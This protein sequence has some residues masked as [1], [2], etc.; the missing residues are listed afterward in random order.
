MSFNDSLAQ[1]LAL[2]S[3]LK[4]NRMRSQLMKA[5]ADAAARQ[6][7]LMEEQ[8]RERMQR[9]EALEQSGNEVLTAPDMIFPEPSD[10]TIGQ[11]TNL[12]LGVSDSATGM[13]LTADAIASQTPQPNPAI[14]S[15]LAQYANDL[16]ALRTFDGSPINSDVLRT[17]GMTPDQ[18]LTGNLIAS[19]QQLSADQLATHNR[20]QFKAVADFQISFRD[21]M[22]DAGINPANF[23]SAA[24]LNPGVA[25][26]ELAQYGANVGTPMSAERYGKHVEAWDKAMQAQL[27]LMEQGTARFTAFAEAY[28]A[29]HDILKGYGDTLATMKREGVKKDQWNAYWEAV[30]SPGLQHAADLSAMMHGV[31]P[32]SADPAAIAAFESGDPT[33]IGKMIA[34]ER[35]FIDIPGRAGVIDQFVQGGGVSGFAPDGSFLPSPAEFGIRSPLAPPPTSSGGGGRRR[36][37]VTAEDA[38]AA[39]ASGLAAGR[40]EQHEVAVL[41][42]ALREGPW[43]PDAI[44]NIANI[45]DPKTRAMIIEDMQKNIDARANGFVGGPDVLP[46]P[47]AGSERTFPGAV[48]EF[49][50]GRPYRAVRDLLTPVEDPTRFNIGGMQFDR[51]VLADLFRTMFQSAPADDTDPF[52]LGI[53][54]LPRGPQGDDI[55]RRQAR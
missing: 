11:S 4:Q 45:K 47:E 14:P 15:L 9:I 54:G 48:D 34:Q 13:D 41:Q 3:Q 51:N 17:V 43:Q 42:Q 25:A 26:F 19:G 22:A 8:A 44:R 35:S 33:A 5:Q 1:G 46:P 27:K 12:G 53:P 30:I 10:A 40:L 18:R 24:Q 6:A 2:G 20:E 7:D 55:D 37:T 29:Q 28:K 50:L 31:Q 23:S 52:S 32:I 16:I 21:Y 36:S 49:V 39:I 38:A